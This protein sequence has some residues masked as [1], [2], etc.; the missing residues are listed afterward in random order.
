MIAWK[1]INSYQGLYHERISERHILWVCD[2]SMN[3]FCTPAFFCASCISQ[4]R[5]YTFSHI[6]ITADWLA[7]LRRAQSYKVTGRFL[8]VQRCKAISSAPYGTG[9]SH[10][11]KGNPFPT[12]GLFQ[13]SAFY[14]CI[15]NF[16]ASLK[17]LIGL[18]WDYG[19]K[20]LS[21]S[22]GVFSCGLCAELGFLHVL[23]YG[24]QVGCK[25]N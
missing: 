8:T 17:T 12:S 16:Q 23:N 6:S 11:A 15:S 22:L 4:Q 24:K 7:G 21:F 14:V 18:I 2:F 1:N 19:Q 10:Q 5:Q 13:A 25:V 9:V 3:V 20:M